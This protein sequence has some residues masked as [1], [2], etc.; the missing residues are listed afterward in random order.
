MTTLLNDSKGI[1]NTDPEAFN[2]E[3]QLEEAVLSCLAITDGSPNIPLIPYQ[4]CP[5]FKFRFVF[6]PLPM[7]RFSAL[8]GQIRQK[9]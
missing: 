7:L 8:C 2:V 5:E 4:Q 9:F 3:R 6:F 1:A